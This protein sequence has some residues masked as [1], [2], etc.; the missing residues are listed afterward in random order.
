LPAD[1]APPPCEGSLNL[2]E[3]CP[4]GKPVFATAPY[5]ADEAGVLRAQLPERC[6]HAGAAQTCSLSIDHHRP[7]KTG[8]CF[9]LAVVGCSR[10]PVGRYTLYPPGHV[11][12][13]RQA[14]VPCSPS[15][16]LQQDR[17]TGEPPW[18]PTLFGAA[19]DAAAGDWWRRHWS[20]DDIRR[21]RSQGRY[22]QRAGHLLGIHSDIDSR[23]RERIATRLRVPTMTLRS[24][25][26][27][28]TQRW[29]DQ[30]RAVLTIL[31]ALPIN[32]SL[33]DRVLAAGMVAGL[34][35]RPQRWDADRQTWVR[36]RAC[37]SSVKHPTSKPAV[38]RAPPPTTLRTAGPPAADVASVS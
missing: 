18:P 28:W 34:W 23:I 24:A 26:R 13:G 30:G 10:H 5:E 38:S 35:P 8:P 6:V 7:R 3:T 37:S 9:A 14:V 27:S 16:P 2:A 32:G 21:R 19:I 36:A 12:Y 31:A 15:G 11:P 25:A 17:A 29:Q 22:L 33:P 1:E 20:K 4:A